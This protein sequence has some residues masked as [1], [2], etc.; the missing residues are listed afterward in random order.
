M[1]DDF[2]Y[3]LNDKNV[4]AWVFLWQLAGLMALIV[5]YCT[6]DEG[7]KL[8]NEIKAKINDTRKNME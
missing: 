2:E 5:W 4:S 8:I 7:R 3:E 1:M 6:I